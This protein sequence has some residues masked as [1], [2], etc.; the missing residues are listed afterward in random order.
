LYHFE[1]RYNEN[2]G[3][4]FV[5]DEKPLRPGLREEVKKWKWPEITSVVFSIEMA[6]EQRVDN[7]PDRVTFFARLGVRNS[8]FVVPF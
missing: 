2:D 7:R 6:I 3:I 1:K 5:P 8:L 4:V